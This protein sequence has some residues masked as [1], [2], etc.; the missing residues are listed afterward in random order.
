MTWGGSTQPLFGFLSH[1]FV[2]PN[3][4]RSKTFVVVVGSAANNAILAFTA[5]ETTLACCTYIDTFEQNNL[6][7]PDYIGY[8]NNVK[9]LEFIAV[10]NRP[11]EENQYPGI[12]RSN[13]KHFALKRAF[14]L[15][16]SLVLCL[17]CLSRVI[18]ML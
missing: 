17:S 5:S 15:L 12:S 2:L 14:I 13:H 7:K 11:L 8:L 1:I 18:T 6:L 10:P 4:V 3:T 9:Y 16:H